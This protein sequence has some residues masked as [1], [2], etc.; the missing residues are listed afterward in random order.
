MR[1]VVG[2][3]VAAI[4]SLSLVP[5]VLA[6]KKTVSPRIAQARSVALG[7]DLGD[8][9]V[10]DSASAAEPSVGPAERRALQAVREELRRWG[11]YTVV[12][13]PEEADLLVAI[14]LGRSAGSF[15]GIGGGVST[16]GGGLGG[17]FDGAGGVRRGSSYNTDTATVDD[18]LAVYDGA[19]G[20]VG[21]RLWRKS[22]RD[23]LTGD[24]PALVVQFRADVERTP[25][26]AGEQAAKP[27]Q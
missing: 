12:A 17:P 21:K 25:P 14:R 15:G 3:G 4:L 13:R 23:G 22:K 1:K 10:S 19:G 27:P 7:Y 6:G 16:G 5:V 9:F 18:M 11:R 8:R 26:P 24:T 20:K 2:A